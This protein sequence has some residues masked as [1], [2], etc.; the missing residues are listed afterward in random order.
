M[1]KHGMS[2]YHSPFG[3]GRCLLGGTFLLL[4]Q[5]VMANPLKHPSRLWQLIAIGIFPQEDA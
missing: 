5:S 1:H 4:P 3:H 2:W